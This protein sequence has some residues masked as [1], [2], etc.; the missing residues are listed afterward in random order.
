MN[1]Y[2]KK[3]KSTR[4]GNLELIFI[5]LFISCTIIISPQPMLWGWH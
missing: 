5:Y 3:K 2:I 4:C 1:L